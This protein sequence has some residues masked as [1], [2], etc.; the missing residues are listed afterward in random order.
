MARG[1]G[2]NELALVGGEIP[3]GNINGDALLA[4]RLQAVHQQGQVQLLAGGA[5]PGTVGFQAGHVILIDH[6]GVMEQAADQR[7][8]TVVHAAAGKQ[9]QEFLVFVLFQ[10]GLD[11]F[12]DKV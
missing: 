4:L 7:A 11:V 6:L 8:F 5:H 9:A 12:G 3:V 1:V 2:D 10:V